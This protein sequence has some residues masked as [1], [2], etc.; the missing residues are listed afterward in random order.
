MSY[1]PPIIRFQGTL[2]VL[3]TLV[4][5][6][7]ILLTFLFLFATTASGAFAK[8]PWLDNLPSKREISFSIWIFSFAIRSLSFSTV[9]QVFK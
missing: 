8:K 9:N 2:H 7:Y 3:T 1:K 6:V 5:F 4:V